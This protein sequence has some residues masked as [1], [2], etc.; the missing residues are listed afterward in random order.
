MH[1]L[2]RNGRNLVLFFC[3]FL[4]F[5][6]HAPLGVLCIKWRCFKQWRVSVISDHFWIVRKRYVV[7]WMGV[8]KCHACLPS[9]T[10]GLGPVF[11]LPGDGDQYSLVRQLHPDVFLLGCCVRSVFTAFIQPL[12]VLPIDLVLLYLLQCYF[13]I[14]FHQLQESDLVLRAP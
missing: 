9:H 13:L 6:G 14:Y 2:N 5:F 11:R 4:C 12:E 3:F 10:S 7:C 1:R 8:L